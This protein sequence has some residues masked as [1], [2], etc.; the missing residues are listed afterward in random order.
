[1]LRLADATGRTARPLPERIGGLAV[2]LV[3][4]SGIPVRVVAGMHDLPALPAQQ[5]HIFNAGHELRRTNATQRPP[6][7]PARVQRLGHVVLQTTK[8]LETLELVP[9]QPRDDRQRLPVLPRPARPRSDDELHPL[10]PRRHSRRPPHPGAG[11][12]P[13]QPLRALGLSGQRPRRAGRRRRIPRERGYFRSWGIGRH[14]QG[15]QI[16]DYW[17]DPDGFLVEHFADGDMFDNTLEP[18]WAPFTASGLAQWGRRSP[19]TS[20]APAPEPLPPRSAVDVGAL[21][22]DNEFDLNRLRGLLKVATS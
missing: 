6:R 21:R 4:P 20:S 10:R 12:G 18:G 5:P 9:R 16:F 14:I 1:M 11:A 19:R 22:D 3:D 8:Y 7:V 17:R 2:D 13:A 15:S